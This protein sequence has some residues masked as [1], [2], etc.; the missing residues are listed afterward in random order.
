MRSL[1]TAP[2]RSGAR[3]LAVLCG[4]GVLVVSAGCASGHSRGAD[5]TF[6]PFSKPTALSSASA[7][8]VLPLRAQIAGHWEILT[9]EQQGKAIDTCLGEDASIDFALDGN[10]VAHNRADGH[11]YGGAYSFSGV[12]GLALTAGQ[13][14]QYTMTLA[15]DAMT[16]IGGTALRITLHR[17]APAPPQPIASTVE[18]ASQ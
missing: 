2:A 17:G 6:V 4:A 10:W 7:A 16:L 18:E 15:G 13:Y 11:T 3:F 8:E 1:G 14:Q 12:N 5:A 9:F